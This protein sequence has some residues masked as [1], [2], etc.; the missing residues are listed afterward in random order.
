MKSVQ[1]MSL[2]K[3]PMKRYD[4]PESG[5]ESYM[6]AA[7]GELPNSIPLN[8][9]KPLEKLRPPALLIAQSPINTST[10]YDN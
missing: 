2:S 9:P 1:P 7:L 8:V 5:C 4:N 10:L 6:P 3:T